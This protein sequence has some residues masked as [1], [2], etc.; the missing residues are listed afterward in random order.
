MQIYIY[1]YMSNCPF[2]ARSN[3]ETTLN[4]YQK[5]QWRETARTGET[6]HTVRM[7]LRRQ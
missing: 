7:A 2:R 3:P 5:L 4:G 6:H 1:I